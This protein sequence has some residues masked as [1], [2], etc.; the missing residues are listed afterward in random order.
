MTSTSVFTGLCIKTTFCVGLC[1]KKTFCSKR[2]M[3]GDQHVELR[4]LCQEEAINIRN[5]MEKKFEQLLRY[6]SVYRACADSQN[7]YVI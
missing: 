4:N 1:I 3:I 7:I 5:C 2:V 6:K